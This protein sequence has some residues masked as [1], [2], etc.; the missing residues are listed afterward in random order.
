M[1][2]RQAMQR[3]ASI[4]KIP[5][6]F[7]VYAED[8][9]GTCRT[10]EDECGTCRT[11]EDECGTCRTVGANL[12]DLALI[13]GS[14]TIVNSESMPAAGTLAGAPEAHFSRSRGVSCHLRMAL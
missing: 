10:V 11:T 4:Y 9:C 3:G 6:L 12:G 1:T 2:K 13:W 8:E 5:P 7:R 14:M